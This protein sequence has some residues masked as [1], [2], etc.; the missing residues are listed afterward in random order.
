MVHGR[1]QLRGCSAGILPRRRDWG[2]IPGV[3]VAALTGMAFAMPLMAF[4]TQQKND[5]A[6]P[7]MNRFVI[8][9]LFL[10]GGAFYPISQLPGG[11]RPS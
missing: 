5:H 4:S 1:R 9:P 7:A 2:L 8:V 11:R 3:F 10:F 6:F